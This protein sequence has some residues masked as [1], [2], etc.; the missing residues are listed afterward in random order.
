MKINMIPTNKF[1]MLSAV[2]C[3]VMLAFTNNA[4]ADAT[5]GFFDPNTLL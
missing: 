5:L 2:A 3:A 1:A 4:R